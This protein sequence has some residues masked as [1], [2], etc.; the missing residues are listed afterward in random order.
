VGSSPTQTT[1]SF[2]PIEQDCPGLISRGK[3]FLFFWRNPSRNLAYVSTGIARIPWDNGAWVTLLGYPA[4]ERGGFSLSSRSFIFPIRP[5]LF[6]G[7]T[8]FNLLLQRTDLPTR[9]LKRLG[10]FFKIRVR[11]HG[12]I[13]IKDS[14]K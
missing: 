13:F 1:I 4:L 5:S 6:L 7:H 2:Q 9:L 8:I 3:I 12:R 11:H 14:P 10:T